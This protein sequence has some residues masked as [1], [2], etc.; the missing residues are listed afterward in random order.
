MLLP[1]S[2]L[3]LCSPSTHLTA[4]A[5]LLLPQPLG[6]TIPVTKPENRRNIFEDAAGISTH[7]KRK[8]EAQSKLER[9][10]SNLQRLEELL[11]D[12]VQHLAHL[13]LELLA[14]LVLIDILVDFQIFELVAQ[15]QELTRVGALSLLRGSQDYA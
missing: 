8:K 10:E 12:T 13:A 15:L 2:A 9:V 14:V 11:F 1:R 6:P 7:K 4:S 5:T 3:A